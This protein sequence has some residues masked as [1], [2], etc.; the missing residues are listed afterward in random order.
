MTTLITASQFLWQ[1]KEAHKWYSIETRL[2]CFNNKTDNSAHIK[3]KLRDALDRG[4]GE[5]VLTSYL[6]DDGNDFKS[7]SKLFLEYP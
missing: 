7:N 2:S 3:K 1:R 6:Q 4:E 5:Q